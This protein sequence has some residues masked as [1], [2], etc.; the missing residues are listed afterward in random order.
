MT[1][2]L[3][4]DLASSDKNMTGMADDDDKKD[5]VGFLCHLRLVHNFCTVDSGYFTILV[6]FPRNNFSKLQS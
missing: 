1:F 4:F 2:R 5:N 3:L 6:E